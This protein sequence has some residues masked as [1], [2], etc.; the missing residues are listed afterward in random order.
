MSSMMRSWEKYRNFF[1][2]TCGASQNVQRNG[3]PR[4]SIM[5]M[6]YLP[7]IVG[8]LYLETSTMS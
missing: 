6:T 2:I 7:R 3:Q 5:E 1:P 8:M 4:L